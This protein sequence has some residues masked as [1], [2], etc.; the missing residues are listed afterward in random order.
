MVAN[1]LKSLFDHVDAIGSGQGNLGAE[2]AEKKAGI[3]AYKAPVKVG[4]SAPSRPAPPTSDKMHPKAK[5]GDQPGEKRM[6]VKDM[7]KPLGVMHKGGTIP[8][9]GAYVMKKGEHVMTPEK[10]DMMKNAMSLAATA[11]SNEEDKPAEPKKQVKE[12]RIR[13]GASGGNIIEHHHMMPHLHPMEEHTAKDMAE[14]HDHMDKHMMDHQEPDADDGGKDAIQQAVGFKMAKPASYAAGGVVEEG[15][16]AQV[17]KGETVVP[18][19]KPA[20]P[21]SPAPKPAMPAKKPSVV[22]DRMKIEKLRQ[23]YKE[24][25]NDSMI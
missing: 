17:H 14:L 5:Y 7:V 19:Q 21:M 23:M 4:P 2:L 25:T 10:H 20:M 18:A 22:Q 6:D 12:M 11:L 16:M 13:K 1:M 24:P 15:G 8:E 3:E 9:T